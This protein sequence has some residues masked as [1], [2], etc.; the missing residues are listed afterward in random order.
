[1]A[2]QFEDFAFGFTSNKICKLTDLNVTSNRINN[3]GGIIHSLAIDT[4]VKSRQVNVASN[5]MEYNTITSKISLIR[6]NT[7]SK[8]SLF[9]WNDCSNLILSSL[10]DLFEKNTLPKKDGIEENVKLNL[11]SLQQDLDQLDKVR[12]DHAGGRE[13][14][15]DEEEGFGTEA[16]GVPRT[17]ADDGSQPMRVGTIESRTKAEELDTTDGRDGRGAGELTLT[18]F[19][20]PNI[21][22]SI[23][24]NP[25]LP[26]R[27]QQK[28]RDLSLSLPLRHSLCE[29]LSLPP[30]L[31]DSEPISS[32]SSA[33]LPLRVSLPQH[34]HLCRFL[35][36][37][38][39]FPHFLLLLHSSRIRQVPITRL[40]RL[41][42]FIHQYFPLPSSQSMRHI[43]PSIFLL[44]NPSLLTG[45]IR[46]NLDLGGTVSDDRIWEV[47]EM[48]EMREIVAG[49]P[50]GLDSQVAEGGSNFS[51]GQRQ[52]LC[53]GRAIL[54][55]CRVVVMD[56]ATANVDV[57]TDAK[58]QRTIREQFGD[59]TGIVISHRLN[60][61][62]DLSRIMAM[63]NG[64]LSEFE[65]LKNDVWK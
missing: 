38:A 17:D 11:E 37:L 10:K 20:E 56:E 45:T 39:F 22:S 24:T 63:D 2:G 60:T 28:H 7:Y 3:K 26:P 48:I 43:P 30:N 32:P 52:L 47:L 15:V 35:F 31:S 19:S 46:Y 14:G 23:A 65:R 41:R 53:F 50:L 8:L 59:K 62:M 42:F 58:I 55:N 12:S 9:Q 6:T 40:L 61:I 44:H 21:P 5:D 36:S 64:Y 57:E 18:S 27:A 33:R 49:L 51:A 29:S 54:N 16:Q 25:S 1:M 13:E 34:K 4:N